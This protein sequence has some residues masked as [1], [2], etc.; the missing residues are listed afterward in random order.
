MTVTGAAHAWMGGHSVVRRPGNPTY[1]GL[2]SSAVIWK[3]L[4]NHPRV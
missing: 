2:D 1:A 3:F 4:I